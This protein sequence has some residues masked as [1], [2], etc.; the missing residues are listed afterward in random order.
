[1]PRKS[2]TKK[3]RARIFNALESKTI[4][5]PNTGCIIWLGAC[6]E[7][8]YGHLYAGGGSSRGR[9]IGA[10]RAAYILAYGD[11]PDN[12]VVMHKCDTPACVNPSHLNLGTQLHNIQDCIAKGRARRGVF[13]GEDNWRTHLTLAQVN[14]IRNAPRPYGYRIIL[15]KR[16]G[17]SPSTISKIVGGDSW[18]TS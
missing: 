8:G 5:E 10:H 15:A 13:R 7:K 18:R 6:K 11:I 14:E 16:F 2:F 3:D 12:T 1:M 17:V 4:P 9:F